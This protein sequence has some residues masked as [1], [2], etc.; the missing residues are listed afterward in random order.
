MI[1]FHKEEPGEDQKKYYLDE[2]LNQFSSPGV[3]PT[4]LYLTYWGLNGVVVT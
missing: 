2:K 3:P 1:K 4:T